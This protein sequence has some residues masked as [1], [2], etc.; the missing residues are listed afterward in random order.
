MP[1]C[2][3][4]LICIA[5]RFP[6]KQHST[7]LITHNPNRACLGFRDKATLFC[8]PGPLVLQ[9]PQLRLP[10]P[11]NPIL[12]ALPN[13]KSR[14]LT[15]LRTTSCAEVERRRVFGHAVVGVVATARGPE[16]AKI[17]PLAETNSGP[18]GLMMTLLVLLMPGPLL[19]CCTTTTSHYHQCD[20][21]DDHDHDH[22]CY[23]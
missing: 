23:C 5:S 22:C 18:N 11:S 12:D 15:L 3:T 8:T 21:D 6:G 17:L 14:K 4:I 7:V 2:Y 19:L 13:L 20:D 9:I 10:N 1:R 16:A